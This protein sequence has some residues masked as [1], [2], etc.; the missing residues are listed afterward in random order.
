MNCNYYT[1]LKLE[2]G[3]IRFKV[4]K[5]KHGNCSYIECNKKEAK[6]KIRTKL[7]ERAKKKI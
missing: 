6:I 2:I 1:Y 3:N 4:F 5:D 7:A